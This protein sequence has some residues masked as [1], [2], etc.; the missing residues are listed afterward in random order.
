MIMY[1]SILVAL[2]QPFQGG[3]ASSPTNL[4]PGHSKLEWTFSVNA[5]VFGGMIG[6]VGLRPLQQPEDPQEAAVGQLHLH[7]RGCRGRESNVI[8][9]SAG[10]LFAGVA[11]GTATGTDIG[12]NR[13]PV[14]SYLLL[15]RQHKLGL[16]LPG[17]DSG[18]AGPAHGSVDVCGESA[19][20]A[21]EEPPRGSQAGPCTSL[22]QGEHV[23]SAV[24]ARAVGQAEQSLIQ[25]LAE[26]GSLYALKYHLQMVAAI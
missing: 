26:P 3:W 14:P 24:V 17:C 20:A 11:S 16:A 25:A 9:F 18:R 22:R 2:R 21:H 19:V 15:L 5:W 4:F 23:H 1:T 10:R 6:S 7:D 13:H 12:A 8:V